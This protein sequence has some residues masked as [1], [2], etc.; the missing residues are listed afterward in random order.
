MAQ[1]SSRF[2]AASRSCA[3]AW[4]TST[5]ERPTIAIRTVAAAAVAAVRCR[6]AQRRAAPRPGLAPGR[7]R[8]VGHPPLDVL[9]QRP[10]RRIAVLR[11]RRHRLEADRL[12][13]PVDRRVNPPGRREL[14]L[15]DVAE[16]VEHL[17]ALERRPARQQAIERGAERVDVR[18]RP[19]LLQI[20]GGLLG[21]HV[22]GRAERRA[23]QRLGRARGR[24]GHQG[25]LAARSA[26]LRLADRLGQAP[27]DDEGLAI[28]ADDHV[29]WLDVPVQHAPAVGV[30][31]RVADVHEPPQEL[32]EGQRPAAGVGPQGSS[33]W[34]A[35]IASLSESPLMNRIA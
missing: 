17:L 10:D 8:L 20:A 34:N 24:R 12:Q 6:R 28:L 33:R 14:P 2:F 16:E 1:S 25:P 29:P 22:R 5:A 23:G 35:S 31:D 30:V 32:A 9:G 7:D 27:V 18:P 3:R 15:A 13:R 19:E 11:P 4:T 21:A 26:D